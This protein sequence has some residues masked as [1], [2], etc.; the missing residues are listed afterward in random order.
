M[1]ITYPQA[2][3][4]LSWRPLHIPRKSSPSETRT[5]ETIPQLFV[6]SYQQYI[7]TNWFISTLNG[8]GISQ[9]VTHLRHLC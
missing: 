5:S 6:K 8:K 1:T 7:C 9:N 3:P 4:A 2:C